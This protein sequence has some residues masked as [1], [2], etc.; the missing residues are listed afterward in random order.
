[1]VINYGVFHLC[2]LITRN[3]IAYCR[4]IIGKQTKLKTTRGGVG[5]TSK[6]VWKV[7]V[8]LYLCKTLKLQQRR[9]FQLN[10]Y[11]LLSS[12]AFKLLKCNYNVDYSCL[13][14]VFS[15]LNGEFLCNFD[16][17]KDFLLF[18]PLKLL[19]LIYQSL[20]RWS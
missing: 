11:Q 1:M 18:Q 2:L 3:I 10:T 13:N 20:Q 12:T 7:C 6:C 9:E 15:L 14:M 19:T 4:K 16:I 17:S 5:F 8:V